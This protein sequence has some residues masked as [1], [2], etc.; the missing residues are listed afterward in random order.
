[1]GTIYF[2]THRSDRPLLLEVT[3]PAG[4]S[5]AEIQQ[6]I[7]DDLGIQLPVSHQ[8][9]VSHLSLDQ[10]YWQDGTLQPGCVVRVAQKN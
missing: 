3:A 4:S 6:A 10:C 7:L 2:Y 8:M 9:F 5:G 1:M